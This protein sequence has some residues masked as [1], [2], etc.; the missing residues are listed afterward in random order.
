MLV[1]VSM[2]AVVSVAV[3]LSMALGTFFASDV[4]DDGWWAALVTNI[5][6][7]PMALLV[8]MVEVA[9][10]IRIMMASTAK[11]AVGVRAKVLMPADVE[12]QRRASS[13][14]T[15]DIPSMLRLSLVP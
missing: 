6:V 15:I 2:V 14:S 12:V 1:M 11:L 8:T 4:G 3:A 9:A 13:L 5:M 10:R 7:E